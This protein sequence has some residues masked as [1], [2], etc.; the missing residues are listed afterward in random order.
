METWEPIV[1]RSPQQPMPG[2]D[3]TGACT[4][5]ILQGNAPV[6]GTGTWT[7]ESGTGGIIDEPDN[8]LSQFSGLMGNAYILH[9]SISTGCGTTYDEVNIDFT[10]TTNYCQCRL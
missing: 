3:Q 7:I 10:A 6:I 1:S 4:P 5:T 8:P 2:P 9:W